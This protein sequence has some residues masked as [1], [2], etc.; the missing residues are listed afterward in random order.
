[1][2]NEVIDIVALRVALALNAGPHALRTT[3]PPS[4]FSIF[5]NFS[6]P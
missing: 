6:I 4:A 2:T 3:P 5:A 1:M